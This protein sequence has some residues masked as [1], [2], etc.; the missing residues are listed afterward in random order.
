MVFT[1]DTIVEDPHVYPEVCFTLHIE[2]P[3][4]LHHYDYTHLLLIMEWGETFQDL[5]P[6]IAQELRISES[7]ILGLEYRRILQSKTGIKLADHS[8]PILEG[9][10]NGREGNND[11]LL[12]LQK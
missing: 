11:L 3:D 8:T 7:K 10:A 5:Q 12:M 6:I 9:M 2:L 4:N 1:I